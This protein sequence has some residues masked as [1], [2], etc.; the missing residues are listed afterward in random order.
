MKAICQKLSGQTIIS[1]QAYEDT[2][3]YGADNMKKMAAC[4]ILGGA[5]AI[6]SCWPQD[7]KAIRS[8]S[9]ELVI[10]GINKIIDPDK[11]EGTY[12]IITPDFE[13]AK[14]V[15]EAGA[16]I[17]ALDCTPFPGRGRDEIMKLLKQIHDTYPEIAIMADTGRVE[18]AE[19]VAASGYVDIVSNTLSEYYT[20]SG[21][22]DEEV[23]RE[24][25]RR[26]TGVL[27]NAEGKIWDLHD[28][29]KAW[30]CGVDMV[31]IGS[32]VT[33]P[34]LIT[35]RFINFSKQYQ[36]RQSN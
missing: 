2:P 11:Q 31:T 10:I 18:D 5:T 34:H 29:K 19:F 3:L 15:I 1:C 23:V 26:C 32:A 36:N 14:A 9:D 7:I 12:P 22:F 13:S 4:A 17:V 35:E 16:D 20:H 33:R 6:R 30:D 25:R 28:L 24:Y 21:C 8:L 27:V